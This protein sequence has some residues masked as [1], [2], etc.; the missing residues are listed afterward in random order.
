MA[1]ITNT[2]QHNYGFKKFVEQMDAIKDK[3]AGIE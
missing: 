1:S 3:D 2:S